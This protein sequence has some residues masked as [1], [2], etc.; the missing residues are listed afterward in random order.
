MRQLK[1]LHGISYSLV[2]VGALNWGLIGLFDFNLVSMIFGG[3]Q[4]LENIVYILIGVAAAYS[5]YKHKQI[6]M[7]CSGKGKK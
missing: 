1:L 2:V 7:I 4:G 6:C 5:V 3:I